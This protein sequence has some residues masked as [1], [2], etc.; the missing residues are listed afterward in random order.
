MLQTYEKNVRPSDGGLLGL[1]NVYERGRTL[2]T[3]V[4]CRAS[5]A[6]ALVF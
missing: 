4:Q 2:P 1:V 6:E 3:F 5:L